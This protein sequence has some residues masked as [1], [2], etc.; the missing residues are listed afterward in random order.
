M[1]NLHYC[2]LSKLE[3]VETINC[4]HQYTRYKCNVIQFS[5][6]YS[7]RTIPVAKPAICSFLFDV[8]R[9]C[10]ARLTVIYI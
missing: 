2:I 9:I 3:I 4:T 7:Q 1:M 10:L 6:L 8:Y 5:H